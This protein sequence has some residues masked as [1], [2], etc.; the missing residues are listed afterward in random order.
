[1]AVVDLPKVRTDHQYSPTVHWTPDLIAVSVAA[2]AAA[3][4]DADAG[5]DDGAD[6]VGDD[7]VAIQMIK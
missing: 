2:A 5:D 4:V 6:G 7:F 3:V 1:M